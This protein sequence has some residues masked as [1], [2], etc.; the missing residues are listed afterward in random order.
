MENLDLK[1]AQMEKELRD[2]MTASGP[3]QSTPIPQFQFQS[4][5]GVMTTMPSKQPDDKKTQFLQ[6]PIGSQFNSGARPKEKIKVKSLVEDQIEQNATPRVKPGVIPQ[7]CGKGQRRDIRVAT[8]DG[9][10]DWNDYRSHFEACASI[11]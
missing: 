1:I 6:T 7:I 2:R 10:G 3:V 9:S 5:S 11:N 4:D 8:Y